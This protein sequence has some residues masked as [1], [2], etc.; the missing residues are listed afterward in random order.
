MPNDILLFAF[1]PRGVPRVSPPAEEQDGQSLKH[2]EYFDQCRGTW[3][4]LTRLSINHIIKS[5]VISSQI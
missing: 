3:G 2:D 5:F 4:K 1:S